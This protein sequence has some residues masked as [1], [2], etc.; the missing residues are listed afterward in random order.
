MKVFGQ[1]T[2]A[3]PGNAPAGFYVPVEF[4][5][6]A[7]VDQRTD[8]GRLIHG[9]GFSTLALPRSIKAQF[10]AT[11]GHDQADIAGRLDE[12]TVAD[13]GTVSGKGWL[14]NDQYGKRAAFL[15]K[16]QAFRGNSIDL[17]AKEKD[18]EV[19]I[20]ED[21]DGFLSWEVDFLVSRLGA[22]TL[23]AEPAFEN[24]MAVIPDGWEVEGAE[25]LSE[26]ITAAVSSEPKPEHA[27]CFSVVKDRPK[28][29]S[30]NF[31][32][33]ELTE[34]TPIF[35][36]SDDHVFGHLASWQ[37]EHQNL[38]IIAPRSK[39]NY[40]WYANRTVE[41]EDGFVATGPLV[42]DGNHAD[43]N[44]GIYEAMDH[45]ANTCLAWADVCVGEDEFGIWMSGQVRP[46]TKAETVYAG[47]ASGVS[48]DWRWVGAG[49]ELIS[50]LSVNTPAFPTPRTFGHS[51]DHPLTIL[52][53][54]FVKPKPH[55]NLS[56]IPADVERNLAFVANTF[57]R[58][59]LE[60][61]AEKHRSA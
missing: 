36:D 33:P 18:V 1:F 35:V 6:L 46:G 28:A 44:L 43:V 42:I 40:A 19:N 49:H 26:A 13:D 55:M 53:A 45:Y 51:E 54:G 48:G 22:T 52:S 41:T 38:G 12:V 61:L 15:I 23:V 34:L 59:E 47:R 4:P 20:T 31:A 9:E 14:L 8:D 24:A 57:A 5:Q 3:E 37:H 32:N 30:E 39:S 21:E 2:P 56:A 10:K 7:L 29:K 11:F 50:V 60:K 16:T 27:F 17:R 25:P 58:Q